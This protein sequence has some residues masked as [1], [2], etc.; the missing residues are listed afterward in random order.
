MRR[1]TFLVSTAAASLV[2]PWALPAAPAADWSTLQKKVSDRLIDIHSPLLEVARNGGA[3]A[4][5]VFASLK[6]PYYLSDEPSL[7]QTLGWTD[8]WTSQPSLKGVAAESASD[9]SAAIDFCRGSGIPLIVKGGG[10][11]YFGNSNRAGSLLVWT[12]RLRRVDLHDAFRP[13][14]APADSP[15]EPAV[16]VGAGCLWGEVYRKVAAEHGRYVQGGGCLT[17]GVAGLVLGGGFGSLSKQFGS[18]ASN[19]IEAE[20]VTPDGRVRIA[21]RWQDPELFFALRGGGGGTFGIVTRLTLRTH[22]LP[23]TIGA[24][25]FE[26]RA[27][28]EASWRELVAR[29]VDFYAEKLFNPIW[30][31]Q[32]RFEPGWRLSVTM[33]CHGLSQQEIARTWAPFIAWAKSQSAYAFSSDPLFVALPAQS[34]WDPATLVKLPGLVLHDDRPGA[35]AENIYWASNRSEAGQTLHAYQ[36]VWLANALL[37]PMR[38]QALTDALIRAAAEWSITLHTNKGL[39]GGSAEAI[40][41]TRETAT[42]PEVLN[43]FALLI[44][45]ADGP[46]AWPGI[47]GHQPDITRGR[48]EAAGVARAMQAIT[49][50]A[51]GAGSY[52]SESDYFQ[53]DW[54]HAHWGS[55]YPRLAAAKRRYDPAWLLRGH[56]CVEPA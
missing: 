48:Q 24:A 9:V 32:I 6:N 1:R 17:V 19:L 34:F 12:H 50:I 51:P 47:P 53:K 8:A 22:P 46:S 3:G 21:N 49:A 23:S 10:H 15:A 33:L 5:Q 7:T 26:V 40:A 16:S 35:P 54:K 28:D 18:G 37:E 44:C 45:A 52:V 55:N 39:G 42:N 25:L 31:E 4:E 38:R 14:G 29:M 20:V 11:S 41:A 43:S 2:R 13:N 36:S 30:G 56:H 27:R